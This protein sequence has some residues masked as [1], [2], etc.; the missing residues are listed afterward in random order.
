MVVGGVA[1]EVEKGNGEDV[2]PGDGRSEHS[3]VRV[4]CVFNVGDDLIKSNNLVMSCVMKVRRQS[5]KK[6]YR[7]F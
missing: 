1:G 7:T 4:V 6:C 5:C 2:N 3:N